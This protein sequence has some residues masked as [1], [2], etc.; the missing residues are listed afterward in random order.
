MDKDGGTCQFSN[1][2]ITIQEMLSWMGDG[3]GGAAVKWLRPSCYESRV[4]AS[5]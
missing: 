5:L 4:A 1:F 3:V 2:Y